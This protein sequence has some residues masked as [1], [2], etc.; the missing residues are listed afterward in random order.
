MPPGRPQG[1]SLPPLE[2][3]TESMPPADPQWGK[4]NNEGPPDLDEILRK[5]QQKIAGL[6]GFGGR[7]PGPPGS[8]G[9]VGTAVGGGVAF[10]VLLPGA[11]WLATGFYTADAGR[12]GRGRRLA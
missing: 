10:V 4:K 7:R 12:R 8:G 1:L 3:P 9:G 5:L 2:T 11:A 6:L